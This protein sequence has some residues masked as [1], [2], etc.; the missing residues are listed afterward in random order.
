MPIPATE[1]PFKAL[2]KHRLIKDWLKNTTSPNTRD[3]MRVDLLNFLQSVKLREIDDLK[4]IKRTDIMK[5][6]DAMTG[7]KEKPGLAIRSVK[8]KLSTVSRFFE[9]LCDEEFVETNPFL[10]VERPKLTANE[11]A[12]AAISERQAMNLLDAPDP[13]TLIG[14]RDRAI[15]AMFLYHALRRS[16]LCQ[17][18]LKD[19]QEREGIK[20]LKILGKGDKERYIPIHPSAARRINDYWQAQRNPTDK[21]LPLFRSHSNNG[22]NA[23][24]PLTPTAVYQLV[25]R[26][27]EK[28]GIDTSNFSPHSLRA[29][30]AT[31]TLS[32]GEDIR[33]VQK[34]LGHSTIQTT[35]MYDKRNNR[36]E[37][38]PTYRVRY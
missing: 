7:T 30:A 14:K 2:L 19:I 26:Y 28:A 27:G 6:R 15:L 1:R 23:R 12:T 33:R 25:I 18:R 5:W 9:F 38:S 17:L 36:P 13:D 31:N 10:G 3:A 24:K 4:N 32:N 20:Q 35:A 22:K 8:R 11:G 34:W 37:D 29:T 21:E 16:E